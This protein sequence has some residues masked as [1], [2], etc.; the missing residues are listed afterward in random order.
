MTETSPDLYTL[1][2]QLSYIAIA[3][4]VGCVSLM[5]LRFSTRRKIESIFQ[6]LLLW[7]TVMVALLMIATL[8]GIVLLAMDQLP[9]PLIAAILGQ[10]IMVVL[11]LACL[12]GGLLIERARELR[13]DFL[14]W[15]S[16]VLV[17]TLAVILFSFAWMGLAVRLFEPTADPLLEELADS[18]GGF[19]LLIFIALLAAPVEEAIYRLGLQGIL[20]NLAD[21]YRLPQ[22]LPLVFPAFAW[23]LGHAGVLIPH[24][25]KELQIFVVGLVLGIVFRRYG[26]GAC[27]AIHLGLNGGVLALH[28]FES[29]IFQSQAP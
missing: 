20:Q 17:S 21:R 16:I 23:S 5:L 9:Q 15:L 6:P 10:W 2:A 18:P 11:A 13:F 19:F 1:I 29:L 4:M 8:A 7:S 27:V 28:S 14:P 12:P 22:W 26:F 25:I 24:G 3:A